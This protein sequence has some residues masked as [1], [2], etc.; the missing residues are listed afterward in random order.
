MVEESLPAEITYSKILKE[1]NAEVGGCSSLVPYFS[2]F[3]SFSTFLLEKG[4]IW[5][6]SE[7]ERVDY[8][9]DWS[10][11]TS[12][13]LRASPFQDIQVKEEAIIELLG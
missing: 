12:L 1:W 2:P 3:S 7:K 11:L 13:I 9:R 10:T 4:E 8:S 5:N 6:L